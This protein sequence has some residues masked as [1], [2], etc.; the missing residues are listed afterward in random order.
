MHETTV[1][2]QPQ[3]GQNP[4]RGATGQ[5]KAGSCVQRQQE[6]Q[7]QEENGNYPACDPASRARQTDFCCTKGFADRSQFLVKML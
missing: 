2:K 7:V 6:M 4:L 5:G 3:L 1:E